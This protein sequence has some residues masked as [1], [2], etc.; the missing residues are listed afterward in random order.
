[1]KY[2]VAAETDRGLVK[3]INQ[4]SLLIKHGFYNGQEVLLCIVCDGLGGLQ[5]GE[6]ASATVIKRFSKWFDEEL[7][8][9]LED[10]QPE[11]ICEKWSLI[12]KELNLRISEFGEI[13]HLSIG[14]TFTGVLFYKDDFAGAHVGDTRLYYLGGD[15]KQLTKDQTFIA[16]EIEKGTM[17]P[18]EA[19]ND[20]RKNQLLQ[21]VGAS[22]ELVPFLFTGK[23]NRGTYLLC[24]DGFR[25]EISEEE[26]FEALNYNNN[27]DKINI[28][29]N[30]RD[31][32]EKNKVRGEK[33]NIS[34]LLVRVN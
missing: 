25:H 8:N 4:D 23:I 31:L 19:K 13:G 33:D 3:D 32:I 9:E 29:E 2:I 21:C 14:T 1:M 26:M 15:I 16:R 18:E 12:L 28:H 20:R 27:I 17:T 30:L 11:I 10:Y 34:G 7:I 6:L 24:S 22:K 5:N